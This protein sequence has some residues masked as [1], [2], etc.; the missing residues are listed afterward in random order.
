MTSPFGV[1]RECGHDKGKIGKHLFRSGHQTRPKS[2][3]AT[4][5]VSQLPGATGTVYLHLG[6]VT[7]LK[8]KR[9][10]GAIQICS[11]NTAE[12]ISIEW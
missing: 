1:C 4:E 11:P 8:G 6:H 3:P 2:F 12:D 10:L 9:K 7:G 5:V